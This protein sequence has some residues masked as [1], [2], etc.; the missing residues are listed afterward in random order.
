MLGVNNEINCTVGILKEW[1]SLEGSLI[2]NGIILFGK[3][4]EK[5]E[6]DSYY[7]FIITPGKIR[8]KNI[9]IWRQLYGYTQK[10][11]KKIYI[12]RGLIKEY[13]G[14]K[15]AKGVF[16]IPLE[17]CQKIIAFLKKNKFKHEITLF[18]QEKI[19]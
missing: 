5:L 16:I 9:S 12:K 1:P 15:L 14:K 7:L 3:Y 4:K 10:I 11:G 17:H 6:T 2:A 13:N 19:Q 8:N 18:W